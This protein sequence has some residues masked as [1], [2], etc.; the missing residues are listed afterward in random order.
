MSESKKLEV[1]PILLEVIQNS[2][3]VGVN[4]GVK[5]AVKQINDEKNR[6]IKEKY[7]RKIRN[8][9]LLL[10]NYRKFKNHIKETTY[11]EEQLNTS[12]V[13]EILD[14]LYI[15]EDDEKDDLTIVQSIL[16]SKKR[17]EIILNHIDTILI[18]YMQKANQAKDIEMKR[19]ALVI[20]KLYIDDKKGKTYEDIAE[21]LSISMSTLKRDKNRAITEISVLMFGIDGIRFD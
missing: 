14:K 10:S 15:L 20:N 9:K 13:T 18:G 12:T 3:T 8:T 4:E 5:I 19:R 2:V 6:K 11:T 21:E 1:D 7:D 16:K 17:T